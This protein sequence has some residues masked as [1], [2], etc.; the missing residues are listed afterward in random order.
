MNF[1]NFL[2][3]LTII[4]FIITPDSVLPHKQINYTP[5]YPLENSVYY[6]S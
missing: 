1:T 3:I 5:F 6:R 2:L 4:A